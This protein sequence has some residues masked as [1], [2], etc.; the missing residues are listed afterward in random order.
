M[1]RDSGLAAAEKLNMPEARLTE[2]LRLDAVLARILEH[3]AAC[4][5]PEADR[6]QW[7]LQRRQQL[8][9]IRSGTLTCGGSRCSLYCSRC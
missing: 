2:P 9:D 5:V 4:R 1:T 8:E 7:V 6:D 3:I